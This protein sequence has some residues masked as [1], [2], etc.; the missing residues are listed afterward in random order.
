MSFAKEIYTEA[1]A[2]M[3]RR[4]TEAEQQCAARREE[5]YHL[6]PETARLEKELSH[7][8]LKVA[9]M[10]LGAGERSAALIEQLKEQ[11]LQ[12]QHRIEN[13]LVQNGFPA[14]SLKPHYQCPACEDT[15]FD[16][17][18]HCAC[19][20]QLL[21]QIALEKL[22]EA[23]SM[24]LMGFDDFSLSYYS[25]ETIPNLGIN[26]RL[27]MQEVYSQ[28]RKYADDFSLESPSLLFT[29]STGLG[30]THLSLAIAK[31]AIGKGYGTLYVTAQKLLSEIEKE[32][33][34]RD[35]SQTDTLELASSCDFL[36]LDDLGAE[37]Q[38]QFT[39]TM[40]YNLLNARILKKLPFIV[41]TNLNFEEIEKRYTQRVVSR[42][43]G[44][45]RVFQF[46][47]KDIRHIKFSQRNIFSTGKRG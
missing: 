45:C 39:Q 33:F 26:A 42:I 40:V 20:R 16:G 11:N 6:L 30:K 8:G 23:S 2:R 7:V 35:K 28:C 13:L 31:E 46:Y 21:T 1:T 19:Y 4:R 37:F 5:I 10:V 36:V 44:V 18:Y 22:N 3:Q 47:G 29:G 41:N 15:G 38:S 27:L 17:P 12:T 25:T 9:R 14:D 43:L 32:H 24:S 34:Q